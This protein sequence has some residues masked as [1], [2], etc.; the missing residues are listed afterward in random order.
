MQAISKARICKMP[1][2]FIDLGP[3]NPREAEPTR[4]LWLETRHD[5]RERHR[6]EFVINYNRHK[7]PITSAEYRPRPYPAEQGSGLIASVE[8]FHRAGRREPSPPND[9]DDAETIRGDLDIEDAETIPGDVDIDVVDVIDLTGDGD[10]E[11]NKSAP[12]LPTAGSVT[13]SATL[14]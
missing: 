4:W 10:D 11:D 13:Q 6:L 2:T 7:Y 12:V 8:E 3:V 14:S 9:I 1:L 5:V